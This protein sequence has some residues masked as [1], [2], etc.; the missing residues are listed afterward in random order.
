[1]LANGPRAEFKS[2]F[3]SG[4]LSCKVYCTI[5]TAFPFIVDT[6]N[7][8]SLFRPK[9]TGGIQVSLLICDKLLN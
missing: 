2:K 3:G 4:F 1:M 5:K 6:G 9:K 8:Y 7:N